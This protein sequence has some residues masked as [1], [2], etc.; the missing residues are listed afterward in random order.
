MRDVLHLPISIVQQYQLRTGDRI[1][2]ARRA[3]ACASSPHAAV[4]AHSC[5]TMCFMMST[6]VELLVTTTIIVINNNSAVVI[7][8]AKTWRRHSG[9]RRPSANRFDSADSRRP[10]ARMLA[11][12]H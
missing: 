6:D 8:G 4:R 12:T 5:F 9:G 10:S 11:L 3:F 1:Q 2:L 7:V